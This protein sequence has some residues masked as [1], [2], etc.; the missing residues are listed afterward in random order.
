MGLMKLF[1]LQVYGSEKYIYT[2]SSP[3]Y[4]ATK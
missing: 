4:L 2:R 1:Q 3:E